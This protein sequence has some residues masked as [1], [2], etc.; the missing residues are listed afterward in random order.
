MNMKYIITAIYLIHS[1]SIITSGQID[2]SFGNV[3]FTLTQASRRDIL[4]SLQIQ[5]NNDIVITGTSSQ[6][7][8]E[9]FLARYTNNGV[10]DTTFNSG[11][12]TPGTNALLVGTRAEGYD[13]AL[14]PSD[15]K[16][17]VSGFTFQTETNMLVAR[18]NTNGTLDTAF[19]SPNGYATVTTGDGSA[20][21]AVGIQSS[22]NIIVAGVSINNETPQFTLAR[23]IASGVYAG[24][25]DT[26]F[27]TA[28]ITTT[29]IGV[30]SYIQAIAIVPS[31][32]YQDYIIVLGNSDE[33]ITLAR[34]TPS[35][36]LDP[37]FGSSG[38][39]MPSVGNVAV[40][41]D[42]ILDQNNYIVIAGS[43][44]V[45]E[46]D[47]D[48][49]YNSLLIRCTPSGAL[50]TSFNGTG[51]VTTQINYSSE[52]YALALQTNDYS[53]TD[54]IIAAGYSSAGLT[55]NTNIA[56]YTPSGSLNL[57]YGTNGYTSTSVGSFAFAQ[58]V[59]IQSDGEAVT[60]GLSDSTFS[61]IRYTA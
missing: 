58:A 60:A 6:T 46:D 32:I 43:I 21:Y 42:M 49:V 2:T 29:Q 39:F 45:A 25:L 7:Y 14:Q 13:L 34:Y 59:G 16:I 53:Y 61:L 27:G 57:S 30:I 5:T 22:G 12:S 15:Q 33:Q 40:G 37:S 8:P 28:G 26:S 10:L 50:D 18:Y 41:Y 48:Q 38:I 44:F 51:Y 24:T 56:R 17:V 1:V 11:G 31:G 36:A 20:A 19:N 23:F 9:L 52:F 35:G 47:F 55:Y 3:G 4:R 54:D